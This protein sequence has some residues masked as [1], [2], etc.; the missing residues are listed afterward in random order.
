MGRLLR[1]PPT[2]LPGDSPF[3]YSPRCLLSR[4]P[5]TIIR[6]AAE[7]G[8]SSPP[9]LRRAGRRE[10]ATGE[11]EGQV[12]VGERTAATGSTPHRAATWL[13]PPLRS[14]ISHPLTSPAPAPRQ[15]AVGNGDTSFEAAF[16]QI[17]ARQGE[18]S[19]LSLWAPGVLKTGAEREKGVG[20]CSRPTP[21]RLPGLGCPGSWGGHGPPRTMHRP[22]HHPWLSLLTVLFL[23]ILMVNLR[24][25][26]ERRPAARLEGTE[27]MVGSA[28]GQPSWRAVDP[29]R[30]LRVVAAAPAVTSTLS[31]GGQ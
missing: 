14:V 31:R 4:L 29:G 24:G 8:F 13:T 3:R 27:G 25:L 17:P 12:A 5:S 9:S 22:P 28:G 15:T 18:E 21:V 30:M 16:L 7:R 19:G 2:S 23:L 20:G 10:E 11:K 6:R 26:C 1:A